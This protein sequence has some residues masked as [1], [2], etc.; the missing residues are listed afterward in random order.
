MPFKLLRWIAAKPEHVLIYEQLLVTN[1]H[2]RGRGIS[3]LVL[4][5]VLLDEVNI[6]RVVV[7]VRPAGAECRVLPV[8]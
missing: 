5:D 7:E 4:I 1:P 8:T 3:Y 6:W 2:T